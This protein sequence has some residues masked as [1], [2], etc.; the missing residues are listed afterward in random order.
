MNK[1]Q[2][3]DYVKKKY[4]IKK[5]KIVA[6]KGWRLYYAGPESIRSNTAILV[7]VKDRRKK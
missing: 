2:F 3:D 7:Y 4:Y 1:K 5:R 6:P